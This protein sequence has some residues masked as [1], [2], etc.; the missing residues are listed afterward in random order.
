MR[1]NAPLREQLYSCG[2]HSLT[3]TSLLKELDAVKT[4][5]L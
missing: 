2:P 1:K 4:L 5:S 3:L